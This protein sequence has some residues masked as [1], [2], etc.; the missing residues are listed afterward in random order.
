MVN[1]TQQYS[2]SKDT[3]VGMTPR[4]HDPLM[5]SINSSSGPLAIEW[6][7]VYANT[8]SNATPKYV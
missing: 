8:L 6:I 7:L 1:N 3:Y 2:A 5:L 4:W